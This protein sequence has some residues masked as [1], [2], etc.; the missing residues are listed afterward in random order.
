MSNFFGVGDDETTEKWKERVER[1]HAT[2]KL[3]GSGYKQY[4]TPLSDQPHTASAFPMATP[5]LRP[6]TYTPRIH[7]P[8][9]YVT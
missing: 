7:D 5:S 4:D 8:F 1:M 6:A 9:R 2:S 3:V